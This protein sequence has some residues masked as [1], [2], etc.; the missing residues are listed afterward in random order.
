MGSGGKPNGSRTAV[1]EG[2]ISFQILC[3]PTVV[4]E[5]APLI[6]QTSPADVWPKLP[7]AAVRHNDGQLSFPCETPF[8]QRTLLVHG[9]KQAKTIKKPRI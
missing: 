6:L 5:F 9:V 1:C 2:V 3:H 4:F 8:A 7:T